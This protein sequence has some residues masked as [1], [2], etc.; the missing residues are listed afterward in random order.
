MIQDFK[1]I[2]SRKHIKYLI[3]LLLGMFI[4]AAIEM[5]G[6]GSIPM[7][8]VIIIDID[9]LIDKFPHFFE[10][11]YIKNLEQDYITIFGGIIL[12]LIFLLKNIYLTL[13]LFFQ[14]KVIKIL[15]TDIRNKLFKNYINAP[16]SFH[17]KSSPAVLIRNI[18]SCVD[19][20][21]STILSTL[22]ITRESLILIVIFILLFLNEPTVSISVFIVLILISG[23]FMFFTR[24]TLIS[25]GKKVQ[26]LRGNQLR[27]IN[28]ALGSIRE[29]KVLNRENYLTNLFIRHVNEMEKHSFFL[30][31]LSQTP[32]IFLEFI[33]VFTVSVTAILFVIINLSNEQIL[34]L[35]SLL[36]VC[37]IRLVPAFNLIISSLSTRRFSMADFELVS[38]QIVNVLIEDK[39]RNK[40]LIGE[41]SYKK[42][43]FKDRIKFENVFFSHENS[44]TKILQNISL[45]IRQG[46][47]IGIIGKSGAGKSTL[48]DIILGL[49][50]PTRGNVLIDN[51]N[52]D[53]NLRN[54]QK[55]MGYVPQDIYLLDDTIRNN[56]AFGLNTN[57]VN[58]EAILKSIELS[59]L[60]DYVSSLEK[61][62]NTVVGNR[63][64]K[65]SGGQKQ[66]IGIARAL[67][68]NPKIL[69]LDEA[70]SS[71]DT[72]N[73]KKIMEEIFNTAENI[74]LIIVTHRHK[75]VSNCDK[76][77]LLDKGRIIDEGK[78]A[79]LEKRNSF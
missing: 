4:A 54:W 37:T 10:N 72:F 15:R 13:F 22:S 75:S 79:D 62:E 29:T 26:F 20:A 65:V 23:I 6:L 16:Y 1:N 46:Q 78:F 32:R 14:G 64:I 57:D 61:K 51:L 74:T 60:K 8:I 3:M 76:I 56:I 18:T 58:Q 59:R 71:L 42:Y 44:N 38:K 39:F 17:I 27:T 52:L 7:F 68:H 30:Y 63:G 73:E 9:I 41:K 5:I 35:I 66:R 28:H 49:I 55:Q 77:Y 12:I 11:S 53:Y 47:K 36:A 40:N 50:K 69:I 25:R 67:Y 24:Q 33:A 70:T 48:I 21:V 43:F 2:C 34:P 19:G 31:F 45:E